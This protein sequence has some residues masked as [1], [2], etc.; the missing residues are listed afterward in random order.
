MDSS[1]TVR[2]TIRIGIWLNV[3]IALWF[4]MCHN[5]AMAAKRIKTPGKTVR[6]PPSAERMLKALREDMEKTISVC[7]VRVEHGPRPSD[8]VVVAWALSLACTV[9][10]P[11]LIVADREKLIANLDKNVTERR[12]ALEEAT[13]EQRR[14][15]LALLVAGSADV[16]P[17]DTNDILRAVPEEGDKPS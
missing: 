2:P 10:N 11:R 5:E 6:I 14:A 8:A 7:G 3:S 9:S 13:P 12:A 17:F 16:A 15:M 1:W 4:G